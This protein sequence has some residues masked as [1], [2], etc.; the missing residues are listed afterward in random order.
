M[1]FEYM[2]CTYFL[3]EILL[4]PLNFRDFCR[5]PPMLKNSYL[6]VSNFD[7]L[8]LCQFHTKN[9]NFTLD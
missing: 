1:S 7:F 2:R 4:I 5:H 9:V 6:G 3:R 8:S